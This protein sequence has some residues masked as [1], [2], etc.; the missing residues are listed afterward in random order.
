MNNKTYRKMTH[1]SPLRRF[2][3]F[4]Q[5]YLTKHFWYALL[6]K[7]KLVREVKDF[8]SEPVLN[9]DLLNKV[10]LV[11]DK[12]VTDRGIFNLS[13]FGSASRHISKWWYE[14]LFRHKRLY[15]VCDEEKLYITV[16]ARSECEEFKAHIDPITTVTINRRSPR[17]SILPPQ[18]PLRLGEDPLKPIEV[19]TITADFMNTRLGVK[20]TLGETMMKSIEELVKEAVMRAKTQMQNYIED[21]YAKI[22]ERLV[23]VKNDGQFMTEEGN[24]LLPNCLCG[25][26]GRPV[27][28][29][30]LEDYTAQCLF[31]GEDLYSIE[32]RKVDPE[33]Y[34]EAYEYSKY[35]LLEIL[36]E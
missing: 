36:T 10:R 31:C 34:K 20:V 16:E 26:C 17:V 35:E 19:K 8:H 18:K 23:G 7:I 30:A 15:T 3:L 33:K 13:Y 11:E 24:P 29:S 32:I 21:N 14:S 4:K 6:A 1:R 5:K 27:F 12:I 25:K 22:N 28:K 2:K 9:I